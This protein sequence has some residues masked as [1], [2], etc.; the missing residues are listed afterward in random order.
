MP[1]L[2]DVEQTAVKKSAIWFDT[3]SEELGHADRYASY[4]AI[5]LALHAV[6]DRLPRQE[7]IA[8]GE[9]LPLLIR[10][11]FYEGWHDQGNRQLSESE[12]FRIEGCYGLDGRK[13]SSLEI[14]QAVCRAMSSWISEHSAMQIRAILPAELMPS[15]E[16]A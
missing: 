15:L 14:M 1:A 6:R 4:M 13:Y 3:V 11:I 12:Q 16:D 5:R 7:A 8:L 10:G 2:R 9:Q